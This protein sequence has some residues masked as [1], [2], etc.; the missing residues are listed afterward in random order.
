MLSAV[1]IWSYPASGGIED[2]AEIYDSK[3]TLI[4]VV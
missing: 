4:S 3:N 2:A 1:I